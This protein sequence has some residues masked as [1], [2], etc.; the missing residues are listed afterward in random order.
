M[1]FS[2]ELRDASMAAHTH[3]EGSPFF[4]RLSDGTLPLADYVRLV[5]QLQAV[6]TALE[7]PA[8]RMRQDPVVGGF[9][10]P[11][12]HRVPALRSDLDV[13]TT[14]VPDADL[15]L[16]PATTAFVSRLEELADTPHR[17]LAHHYTRYLGDLSGG[18][19]LRTAAEQAYG[20]GEGAGSDLFRF[21]G[22]GG[23]GAFKR[24]Y[25][26]RLDDAAWSEQERAEVLDEVLT[27]YRLN[28]DLVADL[29]PTR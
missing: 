26:A 14:R 12:L 27:A 5:V 13:L 1:G 24:A 7:A 11:A 29:S 21:P 15:S 9:V 3:A 16:S 17:W 8:D 2:Q 25:R 6:Y 28:G 4:G 23:G 18:Q 20:L 19:H 10:E 22:L